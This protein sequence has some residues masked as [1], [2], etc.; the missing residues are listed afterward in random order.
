MN[1]IFHHLKSID[2]GDSTSWG[3]ETR[4]L[5]GISNN[6]DK[7]D[8]SQVAQPRKNQEHRLER[9]ADFLDSISEQVLSYGQLPTSKSMMLLKVGIYNAQCKIRRLIPRA[10]TEARMYSFYQGFDQ[11][12]VPGTVR[13]SRIEAELDVMEKVSSLKR[14]SKDLEQHETLLKNCLSSV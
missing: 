5:L 2:L 10:V 4:E 11:G 13:V 1:H 8:V 12:Q 3:E 7:D 9:K 14:L 6:K